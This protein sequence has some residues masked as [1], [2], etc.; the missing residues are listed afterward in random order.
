MS[1]AAA[2]SQFL[3][4]SSGFPG[5]WT[6]NPPDNSALHIQAYF[7]VVQSSRDHSWFLLLSHSDVNS[8]QYIEQNMAKIPG[9]KQLIRRQ[10]LGAWQK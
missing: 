8:G 9:N 6:R 1:D 4:V 3:S 7:R 5:F 10:G 2:Y